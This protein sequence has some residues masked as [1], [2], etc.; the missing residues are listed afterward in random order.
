M[1]TRQKILEAAREVILREGI[2]KGGLLYHFHSKEALVA[3]L[4]ANYLE[5]FD[6]LLTQRAEADPEDIGRWSRAN[7]ELTFDDLNF[8]PP[9]LAVSLLAAVAYNPSLLIPVREQFERWQEKFEHDGLSPAL[10][11][12]LRLA[13]D[14]LSF[15]HIFG[16][17]PLNEQLLTELRDLMLRLTRKG[18]D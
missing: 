4:I 2:S 8:M 7:I 13:I 10:A 6:S 1:T 17:A 15:S 5:T 9:E 3:G 16:N 11:T 14:G 18:G 12:L